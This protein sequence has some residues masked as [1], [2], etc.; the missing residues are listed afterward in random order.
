MEYLITGATGFVGPHLI[1]LLA[2]EGH[3]VHALIRSSNV[4][5]DDIRDIVP[6]R[7][8]SQIDFI[9]G[10]IKDARRMNSIFKNY[11]LDG[12]F[13][14]A[15][16]SNIPASFQD[17]E[18]TF[19][20]NAN[21]TINLA[22]AIASH[23]PSC[24]M[25]FCSTS[26]VYGAVPESRSPI[27]EEF[28]IAPINMY[29]ASKAAADVYITTRAKD[30]GL[31]FFVTRAFSHTGPR[32]GRSFSIASDAYQLVRIRKGLQEPAV[33]VGTLS[34]KRSVIDVRDC[35]KAYN[36]LMQKAV[37]GEAYNV[38]GNQI[39]TMGE[40][41][42]KM[43]GIIGL[44]GKVEKRVNPKLVRPIDIPVQIPDSSKLA[45]VTGWKTEIPIE[46]TLEDLLAYWDAKIT[47]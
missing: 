29:G 38:G 10:D 47:A 33:N 28:P 16:Q 19:L 32:R 27:T 12:V 3:N 14:L 7:H 41:L 23:Q 4:R 46:K 18:G 22:E 2:E 13:H 42:E 15:A 25:M 20:I 31:P 17:P 37:P 11:K 30:F 44:D 9:Y 24:R 35:V 6:D 34:S 40:L 1:N 43:I 5:E 36:L 39:F 8:F 26:E 21:G 45:S